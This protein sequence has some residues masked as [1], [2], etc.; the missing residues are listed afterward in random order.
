M[1]IRDFFV[2]RWLIL[3]AGLTT[4]I[5]AAFLVKVGNPFNAG[6]AP[7]CFIRDTAGALGLQSRA[8]FQYLRP[9]LVGIAL[10]SFIAAFAFKEFRPRG[11]SGPLVRFVLAVMLML[12]ALTFLGCPTRVVLRLAGGDLNALTGLAG[13]AAGIVAGI[14]LMRRGFDFNRASPLPVAAGLMV[15]IA[16]VGMLLLIFL[17]PAHLK[18]SEVGF[19][20]EHAAVG[21]S[22]VAGLL[23]GALAQRSRLCFMGAWR[24]LFLIKNTYLLTGVIACFAGALMVNILFGQFRLGFENQP[25]A[26]TSHLWN[27][28]GMTLV[29]LAAALLGACPLRQIVLTGQGDTDA[30][31][32]VLGMLVGGAIAANFDLS[33][34]E[35]KLAEFGPAA[36]IVGLAICLAIGLFVKPVKKP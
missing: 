15:P 4:G 30:A 27:F 21:F 9:E 3:V 1:Y 18:Y 23:V 8:A 22:L 24:D 31:V 17:K 28:L 32:T 29:G 25:T 33:S 7:T 13:M 14:L 11:G 34:C 12:G 5:V 36:V 35:G 10:G 6:I 2:S 19:G 20:A 26:Q 16:M